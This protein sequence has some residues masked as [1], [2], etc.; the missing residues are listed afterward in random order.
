MKRDDGQFALIV[1]TINDAIRDTV[2][3][4]GGSKMVGPQLWPTK[5]SERSEKDLDDCLNPNNPR[6][7][8]IDEILMIA[9][10]GRDKGIHLIATFVCRDI[11]YADPVPVNPEDQKTELMREF[12][13][14][15]DAVL[16]MA[17][18]IKRMNGR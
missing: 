10:L 3:A 17:H 1:D 12:N 7:L 8:D 2:R 6:K 11:G 16:V 15:V 14:R 9:R 5:K 4:L 13:E 18:Q